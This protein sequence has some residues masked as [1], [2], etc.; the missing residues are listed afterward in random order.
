[1]S[2]IRSRDI[3]VVIPAYNAE[4]YIAEAV[5]SI[6]SQTMGNDARIIV[7]DDG[8]QDKTAELVSNLGVKLIT[9]N[10]AP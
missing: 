1:M 6:K 10:H 5:N 3:S 9:G 7:V 2:E 8:S 4:K